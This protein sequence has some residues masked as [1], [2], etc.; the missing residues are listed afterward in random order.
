[1]CST[2]PSL[3][4]RPGARLQVSP[5]REAFLAWL[6]AAAGACEARCAGGDKGALREGLASPTAPSDGSALGLTALA[7]RLCRPFLSGQ[8]KHLARLDPAF[9]RTEAYR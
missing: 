2:V 6:W 7:L 1:M 9:Y 4:S 3:P 5:G 8:D